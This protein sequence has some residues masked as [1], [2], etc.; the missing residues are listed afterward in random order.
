MRDGSLERDYG[1][2]VSHVLQPL[3]LDIVIEYVSKHEG[4]ITREGLWVHGRF[5]SLFI[6]CTS[7]WLNLTK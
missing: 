4:S 1:C 6:R 2:M 7:V 3:Y 5:F